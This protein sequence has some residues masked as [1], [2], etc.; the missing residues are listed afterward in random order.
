LTQAIEASKAGRK[1]G[2]KGAPDITV[3]RALD[4]A[5]A[6]SGI[7]LRAIAY[8]FEPLPKGAT[9]VLVAAEFDAGSVSPPQKAGEAGKLDLS[10][11][12]TH[13]DTG[14]EFRFD[15]VV[16]VGGAKPGAPQWREVAREIDMPAGVAQVRVVVRDPA[17]GALGSVSQRFE[18]PP[19]DVFR[20][21]T[22]ILTDHVEPGAKP[23]ARP[24]PA[25]SAHRVFKPEGG[26]YVQ[27]E[28][29]GAARAQGEGAPRVSAGLALKTRDGKVVRNLP[30]SPVAAN[31]DGRVVRFVGI[32]LDGLSEGGYDLFL[33]VR[34]EVSGAHL[35]HHEPITLTRDSAAR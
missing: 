15:E 7:P 27:F 34:D 8:L 9:R 31:P 23:G 6:E 35:Q 18:V 5:H 30:E 32:P 26:L 33:D 11:V 28:A 2:K 25:I 14:V 19:G 12:A 17:S 22:P 20:L 10:I 1:E 24:R 13:R 16:G 3:V 4:S 21:G 29:F